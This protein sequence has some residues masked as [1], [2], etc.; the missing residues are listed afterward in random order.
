LRDFPLGDGIGN[1]AQPGQG[2]GAGM[3]S[4]ADDGHA[5]K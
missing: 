4:V 1:R 2:K 3:A 5:G